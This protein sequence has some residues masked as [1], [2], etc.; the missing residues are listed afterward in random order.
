MASHNQIKLIYW[1]DVPNIGDLLSPYIISK[2][3]G[4][5]IIYKRRWWG[6]KPY[7]KE[8]RRIFV[9]RQWQDLSDLTHP[10]ERVVL[11][12]G[13]ILKYANYNAVIWGSGFM[14]SNEILRTEKGKIL[15]VRGCLTA[16]K[17]G[18]ENKVA[19]G[20]P[21]L[22]MPLLLHCDTVAPTFEVG[23]IPHWS[24]FDVFA[25]EYSTLPSDFQKQ[26]RLINFKSNDIKN[27]IRQICSCK[28]ILSSSLHGLIIAHAYGIKALWIRKTNCGTDGFKFHD[29]FSSVQLPLYDGFRNYS[30]FLTDISGIRKLFSEKG[31]LSLPN[32]N[33]ISKIQNQL[34][35]TF[36]YK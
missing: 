11:G 25:K 23:L 8:I 19:I 22:L 1:K 36:P 26:S 17:I 2:L 21:A 15:A 28:L 5:K 31:A 14:N 33:I 27:V 9:H 7:M 13:S 24:E 30:E 4:R 20:D 10:F 16:K 34:L 32:H 6:W 29:Y 18:Q 12:I 3:S 35:D